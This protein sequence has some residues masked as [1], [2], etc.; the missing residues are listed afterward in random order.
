MD[1]QNFTIQVPEARRK[2]MTCPTQTPSLYPVALVVGQFSE[3][4]RTYSPQE[5]QCYP[6]NS[7]LTNPD[8]LMKRLLEEKMKKRSEEEEEATASA[9]KAKVAEA[10]AK[11]VSSESSSSEEEE[12]EEEGSVDS[13]EDESVVSCKPC[14][15]SGRIINSPPLLPPPQDSSSSES[16][17]DVHDDDVCCVCT[18]SQFTSPNEIPELFVKCAICMKVAH[19]SCIEMSSEMAKRAF[20]YQW[21]CVDCKRC[22]S[23][24]KSDGQ[25]KMIYCQQCDRAYH[26]YCTKSLQSIPKGKWH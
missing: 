7:A 5:L 24:Q 23:C 6:I 25:Q 1:L 14:S 8:D 26:I 11:S 2:T 17:Y 3:Y 12:E 21:Q 19:P 4:Y 13:D 10:V 9:Q 16:D 22:H 18:K 15:R 20:Q